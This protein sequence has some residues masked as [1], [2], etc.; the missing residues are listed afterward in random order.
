MSEQSAVT[1]KQ[2]QDAMSRII[3]YALS[4]DS[5]A[6]YNILK[7]IGQTELNLWNT[8]NIHI[9]I[10]QPED[11]SKYPL[12]I[13]T[14]GTPTIKYR[15]TVGSS[16][17]Y[18]AIATGGSG[19]STNNAEFSVTN[20]GGWLSK[21]VA[22][23]A[24]CLLKL[25]WSSIEDELPTGNGTLL[26][27]VGGVIRS[28]R[29]ISQGDIPPI[30]IGNYLILG[31]NNI[32]VTISDTYGNSRVI[33][34]K[35]TC[36][37]VSIASYFDATIPYTGSITYS[38]TPTGAVEKIVHF[39]I[40][41]EEIGTQTVTA[42]GRGQ[43]FII[44]AQSH[45]N[46]TF[47]VYFTA[48]IDSQ[49]VE[50]NR[51]YYDLI[52]IEDGNNTP[53]IATDFKVSEV[54]QF[55]TVS[56]S[57]IVYT[58][59]LLSSNIV[60]EDESGISNLT[61]D[62]TKQK[63][64]YKAENVGDIN[65][66]IVCGKTTREISFKVIENN[67]NVIAETTDLECYLTSKGRSNNEENPLLWSYND[68]SA[69]LLG[70]NLASDGWQ[71]DKEGN[72]V[73]RVSGDAR[74]YIPLNIFGED[75]RTSGKTIEI[76]FATRDIL[77]YDSVIISSWN[78]ER[79]L[80]IT[81]QKAL[82]KSAMSEIFTQ[83][84]EDEHVRIAFT[85]E[86]RA[87]NRLLGIYINGIMSGV[88]QYPDDDDFSQSEPVGI[89]IGSNECT[90][91]IY[92][93]RIYKN[94]LTRYQ[95]LDNWIADTQ[96]IEEM[97]NRYDRNNI[98]DDS[99]NIS[100][101]K[102]P[103]DV[104][105]LVLEAE[106][107]AYLPQFK[108]DNL[109]KVSGRYVDPMHPERSFT[110]YDAKID[111]QGTSSQ[112]YARKN[113]KIK[114]KNGFIINGEASKTYQLRDT[115][116]PTDTFTFKADVASSEG[117]NNVELVRLYDD[118]CP[119]DTPPQQIDSRVRQ[120][121]EGYPILM[122]Y[123][124]SSN[125]YFLG[126][127]NFNNDKGTEEVFGFTEG[128]ESWEVLQN[129][130]DMVIWKDDD[131]ST[132]NWKNSFEAR[133][134][135]DNLDTRN[136]NAFST[137]LKSTDTDTVDT[138]EEKQERLNKFK[139]ELSNYANV[140]ALIFNYIFT[141]LFLLVDNR[142]KN[143]FPTRYAADGK[144]L[145]LPYD[146]DT[147]IGINNEGELKFGYELEDIDLVNG[148]YV[149][150]GQDS[151]LF[152]N[153]RLAFH[154]EIMNM[155]KDLRS[156]KVLSY[157][158][159]ESRFE[160]HQSVWGE[161]VFNED[162]RFKYIEP[163]TN[164]QP[165]VEST[166]MYLPMLQGSKAEQRK[167]WL[168]NR[169]RYIDSKY[170]AGDSL[171]DYILLRGYGVSDI[172]IK[173]YAD[174][175]ATVSFDGTLVQCRALRSQ[176]PE[177]GYLIKTPSTAGNG[178]VISIYSAS[179]LSSIGDL[180]GLK[181]GMA[182]FSK[183][184]K[185]SSLKVGDGAKDYEN[186]NLNN[187]TVGNLTL[188]SILDVRNC[189]NLTQAVDISGCTNIE[190]VYFEG[191]KITGV[192]LPNGGILKSLHL[193]ATVTSLI[194]QNQPQLT[195]FI[196]PSYANISTLRLENFN[197]STFDTL[198][199]LDQIKSNS[200]V[201]LLGVEWSLNTAEKIFSVMDKLD[202]F[203]G[204][205]ENNNNLDKAQIKGIIHTGTITG[206]DL[207]QMT[208][209]YPNLTISYE[210]ITS[211]V[212]FYNYDGSIILHGPVLVYDNADCYDPIVEGLIDP[213]T[214]E[215]TE[216]KFIYR[217]WDDD[218]KTIAEDRS[219]HA[220]Y[221]EYRK[222]FIS[223]LDDRGN[224]VLVNN[225]ATNIYY[226][227]DGENIV[228]LP[229]ALDTYS[230]VD[231]EGNTYDHHFEGWSIDG[232]HVIEIPTVGGTEYTINY[233]AVF[234]EHRVY[235]VKFM[236]E[237]N[238]HE[239]LH[240]YAGASIEI[241]AVVPTKT[242]T[243]QYHFNFK[244]WSLDGTNVVDVADNVGTSDI[245]YYAVYDNIL[246]YY[247]ITFLD[248]NGETI[249]SESLP[250]GSTPTCDTPTRESTPQYKYTFKE[251]SPSIATVI[252]T[253]EYVATYSEIERT[254]TIKWIVAGETTTQTLKYGITPTPPRS[255][256]S[257]FDYNGITATL[258]S[259][260]PSISAVSS[261]A[262]YTASLSG[263]ASS[264]LTKLGKCLEN[265][266]CYKEGWQA[267]LAG[268]GPA[269][270]KYSS[271]S[272][273]ARG[274]LYGYDFRAL[275]S[276]DNVI[277]TGFNISIKGGRY[278]SSLNSTTIKLAPIEGFATSFSTDS[279]NPSATR[280]VGDT[281]FV[282]TGVSDSTITTKTH[283][284]IPNLLTWINSNLQSFINGYDSNSFGF[285]LSIIQANVYDVTMEIEFSFS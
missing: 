159:I 233:I 88:V 36:V 113:Y 8:N 280:I 26:I 96:D 284:D 231:S 136:L 115:S 249:K 132:D 236:N 257:T 2:F 283:V 219:V 190:Y 155:Y 197:V 25:S 216:S 275:N 119:V 229:P 180:S 157:E 92:C 232:E 117:A 140:D 71:L 251:W 279:N 65:L 156:K 276:F 238:I 70:F 162:A 93:I 148:S 125:Y 179:Q 112:Y 258:N 211:Q 147:A 28:A 63:W 24:E 1:A 122:F 68:I 189:K 234:S 61:V 151:V 134:P 200:R 191:T 278:S 9:G 48:E 188:L 240:L 87:E 193:P 177:E 58:P 209:R 13:D 10:T 263:S 7:N 160:E 252:G 72:I 20:K 22:L 187:L 222:Y 227:K 40:D 138:E 73:L 153:L 42:S 182:D 123:T 185:L 17:V 109:R 108:G 6:N 262:T 47:E 30:N 104:P 253:A 106:N 246:R 110:F 261:D 74:V 21:T 225:N 165:G 84:K 237:S 248:Y 129:N 51:L 201:R 118:I 43:S 163:L 207:A 105:Y 57:Y 259:W 135:E 244:G 76:E 239:E 23:G 285:M 212:T 143:A 247:T 60:L 14:S 269:F 214:Y 170:N 203:R 59:N 4:K 206:N 46:H 111:V 41:G 196:M 100:I 86:K 217:E 223:F 38:Y 243:D 128:D 11:T 175:Y 82:L 97:I 55:A 35:V 45:G 103:N 133:Y 260:S 52:C 164:P 81:A 131:F 127:Y 224:E 183:G 98:F 267:L 186:L 167:W 226:D 161:A 250:Y 124:D 169:F 171:S 69:R 141:E 89:S 221:D 255:V 94:N 173:P 242:S 102:L 220:L 50:S 208:S 114:F 210:H 154:K 130:T 176:V 228:Q 83:Y 270:Y 18:L 256:G 19:G 184:T 142:A 53:I 281:T 31:T 62:R 146:Y 194:I 80:K 49:P 34:F 37:Q 271:T 75:F 44:P 64:S 264:R 158:E 174:I 274:V 137:W 107:Y 230:T 273:H 166:S 77:N 168:Y 126:K 27:S 235:V 218:L 202:T 282:S 3:E 205:D 213:P 116:I 54:K 265:A 121:I 268:T 172:Y 241:P 32:Q 245:T 204:L 254:Y 66:K 85:V 181:V 56:I 91:D 5:L 144:W 120:G 139:N 198:K 29:E 99:G 78:E 95:I 90:T 192:S 152:V 79:G 33:N 277:I 67:I 178:A 101:D 12:W 195:D 149:F 150:N 15:T 266:Y 39:L 199:I 16:I 145:I 215:N 272:V